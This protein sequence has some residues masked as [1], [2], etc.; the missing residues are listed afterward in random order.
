NKLYNSTL[1]IVINN[2]QANDDF[3]DA[4]FG[5]DNQE[6]Y[7][8]WAESGTKLG[9]GNSTYSSDLIEVKE[10]QVY[11]LT[12]EYDLNPTTSRVDEFVI[13]VIDVKTGLVI[14]TYKPDVTGEKGELSWSLTE[15]QYRVE[16]II[17]PRGANTVQ[18]NLSLQGT[19]TTLDEF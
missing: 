1:N 14:E 6:A 10:N 7:E 5:L 16:V 13:R 9:F 17:D 4:R 3:G 11:D 12:L 19:I 18:Y 8:G 2:V 15:G